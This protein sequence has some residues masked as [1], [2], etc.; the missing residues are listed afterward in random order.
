MAAKT[1]QP[2]LE[3]FKE[4]VCDV[5]DCSKPASYRASWA[6]GVVIRLVCTTHK[7]EIESKLIE[8]L[9]PS[10]FAKKRRVN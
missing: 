1:P 5:V 7:K 8:Q 9:S 3:P 2:Y 6:Q 4:G 10:T